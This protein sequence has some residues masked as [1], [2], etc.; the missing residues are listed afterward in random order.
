MRRVRAWIPAPLSAWWHGERGRILARPASSPAVGPNGAPTFGDLISDR[1]RWLF[2]TLPPRSAAYHYDLFTK[3]SQRRMAARLGVPTAHAYLTGAAL[4][5]ALAFVQARQLERFVIKPNSSC[6]SIGF[7]PF[8]REGDRFRDVHTGRARRLD[9]IGRDLARTAQRLGRTDAWIV[10]ELLVPPDESLIPLDDHKF[11]CFAGR[12]EF[13]VHMWRS[14]RRPH[15]RWA[16][17]TREWT[18]AAVMADTVRHAPATLSD[19]LRELQE[20][21]EYAAS[22]LCYP[23]IRIDLCDTS[24]G[25]V[26]GEF[27]PGPG[28]RYDFR[29]DWDERL[30]RR[31]QEAAAE[32]EEGIRSGRI[33][34]LTPDDDIDHSAE[35]ARARPLDPP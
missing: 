2:E 32:L 10:E 7:R 35:A 18:P 9:V 12:T 17:Y 29:P 6:S 5:E 31:W 33:E 22:Q 15:K 28:R 13:L 21:A 34:P 23:F 26:L 30:R 19:R 8:V 14:S 3:E 4:D 11:Y 25:V 27:T 20:T 24:R 16:C 1:K